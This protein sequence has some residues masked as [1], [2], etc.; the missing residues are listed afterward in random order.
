M[1]GVRGFVLAPSLS[2]DP[3]NIRLRSMATR[4]SMLAASA[5]AGTLGGGGDR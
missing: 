3:E 1:E 2:D 5:V 4:A